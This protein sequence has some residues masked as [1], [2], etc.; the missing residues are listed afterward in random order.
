MH[1][2]TLAANLAANLCGKNMGIVPEIV[3]NFAL[4][5]DLF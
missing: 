4:N 3:R 5:L 1:F 2:P